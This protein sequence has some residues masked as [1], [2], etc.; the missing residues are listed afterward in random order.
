M[1]QNDFGGLEHGILQWLPP[2]YAGSTQADKPKEQFGVGM[3]Q[4]R[5]HGIKSPPATE[6]HPPLFQQQSEHSRSSDGPR[7]TRNKSNWAYGGSE[8]QAVFLGPNTRRCGTGVF[9][10]QRPGTDFQPRTKPALSPVLLPSR[11]V[12]TL[13]L[14]VHELGQQINKPQPDG[15]KNRVKKIDEKLEKKKKKEDDMWSSP[16]IFL[17]KEWTY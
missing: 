11:V 2:K 5:R 14:N 16:E 1:A 4:P 8:M 6:S 3:Q 7:R 10:P 9:L 13:N 17:P 12:Q 15:T